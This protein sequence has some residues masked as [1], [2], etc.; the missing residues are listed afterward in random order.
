MAWRK[1]H[2]KE[3]DVDDICY[4]P[5]ETPKACA[6]DHDSSI[7]S[8]APSQSTVA[9]SG[10]AMVPFLQLFR[11]AD[12]TDWL[13]MTMGTI[14]ALAVGFS[15]PLQFILYGDVINAFNAP[16]DPRMEEAINDVVIK[17]AIVGVAVFVLGFIQ[18]LCWTI[19][20]T[21]QAK[22]MRSECME[23]LLS[24]EIGWFDCQQT[25]QLPSRIVEA[26][27]LIQEGMGRKTSESMQFLCMGL[28][29]VI[30]G[31]IYGWE[32]ALVLMAFLPFIGL[33]A[34]IMVRAVVNETQRG[35]ESSSGAGAV[36]QEAVSHIRTVQMFNSIGHFVAKYEHA[37]K[38]TTAAG[39]RKIGAIGVGMAL[40]FFSCFC[41]YAGGMYY[42]AIKVTQDRSN[43]C[44]GE[45]CYDG[46]QVIT[47]F[48]AIVVG[49][50][51]FG[52]GAPSIQ[53][54]FAARVAAYDVFEMI[55][56]RSKIDPLSDEGL[57]PER[58]D[59]RIEL[60]NVTFAYPS[61]PTVNVCEH[62]S[63]TIE[64]GKSVALVG[65]SGSGKSTIVSLLERF[66]DP[67]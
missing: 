35:V 56:A 17:F 14:S 37:L 19:S 44:V 25:T 3:E 47:V 13:L 11:Y 43:G 38:E 30:V 27:L 23:A 59:G 40:M 34:A 32:L 10:H 16:E 64:A 55:D 12:G 4:V 2:K 42:G 58:A 67:Q 39:I 61:R 21:R 18:I 62:Y 49:A 28:S 46:G 48:F 57:K 51:A 15:Q 45:S 53:A 65:P 8:L 36:A 50:M 66:Y 6:G 26:T 5:A 20:A 24:R 29:G 63:L 9:P 41:T 54:V 60:Q 22:R 33:S 1:T 7:E 31:L 52:Q